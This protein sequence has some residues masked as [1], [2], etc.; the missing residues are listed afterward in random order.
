MHMADSVRVKRLEKE[1]VFSSIW[2]S[3]RNKKFYK[4]RTWQVIKNG[5]ITQP[6]ALD[7]EKVIAAILSLNFDEDL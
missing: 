2:F 6:L 1:L 7:N 4:N 5:R 3:S